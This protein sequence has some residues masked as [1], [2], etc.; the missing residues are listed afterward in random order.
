MAPPPGYGY[1]AD[2]HTGT[3]GASR[4]SLLVG[5][6]AFGAL[7]A[8]GCSRVPTA[9]AGVKGGDLLS[10]LRAQGVVRLGIAGEVPFG[11]IDK[12]GEL[13]GEAPE[14]AKVVFKRLGVDRVQPVP[15]EFGSL[16]PGLNSQQFDVVSA[17][18]SGTP[19]CWCS[20]SSSSTHCPSGISRSPR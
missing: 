12:D 9:P 15:T 4:R 20:C 11:Y 16:V 6:A 7:G 18:M 13:T 17:G 10:R 3:R 1:E 2:A 8:A 14:L 19:R 5:A